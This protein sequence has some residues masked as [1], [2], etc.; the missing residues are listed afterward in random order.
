[1]R[2]WVENCFKHNTQFADLAWLQ[3]FRQQSLAKFIERGVPTRK[4]ENWKYTTIPLPKW[5]QDFT[6]KNE[7]ALP[8]VGHK[9]AD[10]IRLVFINGYFSAENSFVD[11]LPENCIARALSV[12]SDLTK[13]FLLKDY[14]VQL[15]PFSVLN[16]ALLTDGIYIQIP[17]DTQVKN[18]IHVIYYHDQQHQ[19]SSPRQIIQVEPNASVDIVIEHRGQN[20]NYF[21]NQVTEIEAQTNS[22]INFYKVQ[23]EGE[24]AVHLETTY[25][26]QQQ[27]SRVNIWQFSKGGKVVREDLHIAQT[28]VGSETSMQGFYSLKNTA[29]HMDHHLHVD[30]FAEHG[31]SKMVYKGIID[32]NSKAVFNGKVMVH[33]GSQHINSHQENH[34]L[35]LSNTAEIN[36]KP[37]LEI[38]ADDVKCTHG[39][40]IGEL[41]ADALFFLRARGIDQ[42]EAQKILLSAFAKEIFATIPN[43]IIKDYIESRV[44]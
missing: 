17:K 5:S 6:N 33:P 8:N 14:D 10:A 9:I 43:A 35:L 25:V 32:N 38:Y 34:N 21:V 7:S 2:E 18:P 42:E 19:F 26:E 37:E 11:N 41:N 22:E 13:E 12:N 20:N 1:M 4:E 31:K 40:T 24:Q 44:S 23:D 16:S 3:D 29:Q 36:T 28:G 30:H 15:Q 39:A 27:Q